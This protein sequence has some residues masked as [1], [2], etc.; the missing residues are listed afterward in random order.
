M[1]ALLPPDHTLSLTNPTGQTYTLRLW[2]A[3]AEA[4]TLLLLDGDWVQD[5]IQQFVQRYPRSINIASVGYGLSQAETAVRRAYD[6]T[7]PHPDGNVD[8]RVSTW[9]NGGAAEFSA[10]LTQ[11]VLPAL[12]PHVDLQ[13]SRLGLFGHSYAGLYAL[14]AWL[15]PDTT[16]AQYI[17]ASPS[18]WWRWPHL[19]QLAAG[20]HPAPHPAPLRILLGENEQWHAHPQQPGQVRPPGEPTLPLIQAWLHALPS[21]LQPYCQLELCPQM[22]H[23]PMLAHSATIALELMRL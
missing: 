16:F 22:A 21:T 15:Q 14:Y 11:H 23:G 10:F 18:V 19:H 17:V 20:I 5:S 12:Q 4:P 9:K 2:T 8:P 3:S 1:R 13:T 6:F 7:P